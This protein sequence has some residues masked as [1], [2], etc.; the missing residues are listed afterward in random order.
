MCG[1]VRSRVSVDW[2]MEWRAMDSTM[3]NVPQ[4]ADEVAGVK[5][6]DERLTNRLVRVV[7]ALGSRPHDSIPAATTTR[8]EMEGTYRF[9]ANEKSR[10]N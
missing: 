8:T 7:Q 9:F 4:L 5:F 1:R 2:L 6:G 10:R 3:V